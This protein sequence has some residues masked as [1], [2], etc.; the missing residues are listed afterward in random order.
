MRPGSITSVTSTQTEKLPSSTTTIRTGRGPV[1]D[2]RQIPFNDFHGSVRREYVQAFQ[3]PAS[4]KTTTGE[5]IDRHRQS[6]R[7]MTEDEAGEW[8]LSTHVH[9]ETHALDIAKKWLLATTKE[10]EP[11]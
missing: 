11:S 7:L 8:D 6:P 5:A 9:R 1:I 3:A 10:G 4:R 2:E